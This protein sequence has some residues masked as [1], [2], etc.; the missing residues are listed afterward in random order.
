MN[1]I[2]LLYDVITK[3]KNKEVLNGVIKAESKKDNL[4][5]FSFENEFEKNMVNGHTKAKISTEMD[6]EGKKVKH[7]SNTDIDMPDC[8]GRRHHG[9][10]KDLHTHGPKEGLNRIAFALSV[11]NALKVEEVEDKAYMLSLN[12]NELPEDM[13]M[14]IHEKMNSNH[15]H[16]FMKELHSMD[17]IEVD[18]KIYINKD[19][20][21]EKILL[22]VNGKQKD[23]QT[24]IH[25]MS[26]KAELTLIV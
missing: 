26:T 8:K 13:K 19:F 6:Y 7:E 5:I 12:L 22:D 16:P 9:F 1:K 24:V 15:N 10:M 17:S 25:E 20:E 18:L 2:K 11:L 21:I 3:M 23:E 14:A 4:S